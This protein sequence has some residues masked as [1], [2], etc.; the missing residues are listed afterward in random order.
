VSNREAVRYPYSRFF[1]YSI[2]AIVLGWIII[3]LSFSVGYSV[4]WEHKRENLIPQTGII[5]LQTNK[6]IATCVRAVEL[7][8]G[9][10]QF[11]VRRFLNS[12]RKHP[13]IAGEQWNSFYADWRKDY[14]QF[15]TSYQLTNPAKATDEKRKRLWNSYKRVGEVAK[16]YTESFNN[17]SDLYE[18]NVTELMKYFIESKKEIYSN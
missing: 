18:K 1:I 5:E 2:F 17:L 8:H 15:G 3:S 14:G 12:Y 9:E 6:D 13:K 4:F 10:L 7:L 11:N 16:G